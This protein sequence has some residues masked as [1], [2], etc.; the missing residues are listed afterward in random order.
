MRVLRRAF[1]LGFATAAMGFASSVAA[2]AQADFPTG[3]IRI[4]VGFAPGGSSTLVAQQ[5]APHMQEFLGVPVIVENRPGA[6]GRIGADAVAKAEPDGHTILVTTETSVVVAAHIGEPLPYDPRTDLQP[7][8]LILRT[9]SVIL[10]RPDSGVDSMEQ[11]VALAKERPG[12]ID[13]AHSGEGGALHLAFAL[14]NQALGI[15]MRG[16]SYGAGPGAITPALLSGEIDFTISTIPP[17][18]PLINDGLLKPL[19]VTLAERVEQLPDVPTVGEVGNV[20][21]FSYSSMVGAF[22]PAGIPDDVLQK[23]TD[24]IRYAVQT[25]ALQ[26]SFK[27]NSQVG[28]GST[29]EE[30]EAI[31][32]ESHDMY[33]RLAAQLENGDGQ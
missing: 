4:I 3:P 22:A 24:S 18:L 2:V 29:S 5:V 17:I 1:V 10:T 31:L 27:Q 12:G 11:L 20:P 16:I 8:S 28:V 33:A 23:L 13:Y 7:I 19:A 6:Q 14:V 30:F 9:G 21:D 25:E 26:A 32:E 15:D